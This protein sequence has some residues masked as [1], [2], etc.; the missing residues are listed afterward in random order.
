VTADLHT[1]TTA[2]DG[3]LAPSELV[4][5]AAARGIRFLAV[6]DHD[7]VSGVPEALATAP[8]GMTVIPGAE[9]TCHVAGREAHVLAYGI[10]VDDSEFGALLGDLAFQ[11]E[12]RARRMVERLMALGVEVEYEDVER[13]AGGATL[14]RPH[15][16]RALVERG[17]VRSLDEAFARYIGRS[18]PAHVAKPHR[19]PRPTFEAVR[20][21]GGV[22]VLAHPGT[23][24]RDDL[25]PALVEDGLEGLEVR[26]TEHSAAAT[27]HYETLA[28]DLG[29]LPTGGS[30]FHGSPG[31]R[32]R[33]GRPRVPQEWALNL[34]DRIGGRD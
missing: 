29:L 24:R 1:H 19:E 2:S 22:P 23:F 8:P 32:S 21:A 10:D 25:I 11:R 3:A 34:V 6:T 5:R 31:H 17:H 15:V 20:R 4:R 33:I 30:D 7:S 13:I 9:L 28:R 16:A 27:R 12:V 14:T 26:H 18:G